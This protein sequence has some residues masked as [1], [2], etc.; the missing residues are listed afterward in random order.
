MLLYLIKILFKYMF[1]IN[2]INMEMNGFCKYMYMY[3]WGKK[4]FCIICMMGFWDIYV[5]LY[6]YVFR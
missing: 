4:D 3:F 1:M 2:I 5:M 6:V